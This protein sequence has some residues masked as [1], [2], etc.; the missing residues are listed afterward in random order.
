LA[1][2][3]SRIGNPLVFVP[4][5]L[6]IIVTTQLPPRVGLPILAALLLCVIVPIALVLF[7]G[8][9]SGRWRDADVSVRE[10]RRRFYPWAIPF[11]ALGA[12]ALWIMRV[13]GFVLRGAVVTLILFCLAALINLRSKIS[14]HILFAFYCA[15]I[16][17]RLGLI[18][19]TAASVVALLVFWSRLF[20]GRHTWF[21][22]A[23]GACLGIAGGIVTA[24]F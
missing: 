17:L 23:A 13:P 5:S 11:S 6:A 1:I 10:E 16:L 20:L 3:I 14:L 22:A 2:I 21:E 9:R 12:L 4:V 7:V 19:G 24:W 8:V 15:T 18:I